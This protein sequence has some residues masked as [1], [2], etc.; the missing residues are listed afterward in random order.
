MNAPDQR[1]HP[2]PFPTSSGYRSSPKAVNTTR[3][4]TP[5]LPFS[6]NSSSGPSY[7]SHSTS[8]LPNRSSGGSE[9]VQLHSTSEGEY[10]DPWFVQRMVSMGW[11]AQ[12]GEGEM[13]FS[14]GMGGRRR[15]VV[16]E[17]ECRVRVR[18]WERGIASRGRAWEGERREKRDKR[19]RRLVRCIVVVVSVVLNGCSVDLD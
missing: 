12:S 17:G 8:V 2:S 18:I 3:Y 16:L 7:P 4:S 1:S 10:E 19:G 15:E 13:H 5:Q 9:A 6:T 14:W 11:R